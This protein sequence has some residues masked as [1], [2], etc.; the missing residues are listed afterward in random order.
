MGVRREREKRPRVKRKTNSALTTAAIQRPR[1]CGRDGE[2]AVAFLVSCHHNHC[3][4][5]YL[6]ASSGPK[7]AAEGFS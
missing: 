1:T 6:A 2:A 7:D 5:G 4:D 3:R